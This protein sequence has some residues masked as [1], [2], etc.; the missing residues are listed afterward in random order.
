MN[1]S[2]IYTFFHTE[3]VRASRF[4]FFTAPGLEKRNPVGK[5]K[6]FRNF[7]K[8][9]ILGTEAHSLHWLWEEDKSHWLTK[10]HGL[11]TH[12]NT[13]VY[14]GNLELVIKYCK[15]HLKEVSQVGNGEKIKSLQRT[16]RA[17]RSDT[18]AQN[19]QGILFAV[20][21]RIHGYLRNHWT[22]TWT[23]ERNHFAR[24]MLL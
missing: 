17:C 18:A 2:P 19:P 23:H 15:Y 8:Q 10:R 12:R 14:Q 6:A 4:Q 7:R 24:K 20:L 3:N 21:K 13:V 16:M 9:N 1:F 22:V 11:A 5:E